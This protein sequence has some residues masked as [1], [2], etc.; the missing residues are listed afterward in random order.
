MKKIIL[1]VS[2]LLCFSQLVCSD[3]NWSFPAD[4]ISSASV[5]VND[6]QIAMD[7]NGN[8]TAVW[9]ENGSVKSK[10][11]AIGMGWSGIAILSNANSSWPRVVAHSNGDAT[12]IWLENGIV[13]ASTKP[14]NGNWSAAVNISGSGASTP[15]LAIGSSGAL[16]AVWVRNKRVE[17]STKLA[18]QSWNS[19]L[20]VSSANAF[21]PKVAIGGTGEN[22]KAVAV[23]HTASNGNKIV[24]ASIKPITKA[25][26]SQAA[27][28]D[29]NY[30]AEYANVA[31]DGNGNATAVW[32]KYEPLGSTLFNVYVQSADSLPNKTWSLPVDL[33][34]PGICDP[35]NLTA[36]IAY[37][38]AGNAIAL[39]TM[40]FD[41][42]TFSIQSAYK[43][44]F[45]VWNRAES[46]VQKNLYARS[47]DVSVSA[48]GDALALYMFYN[49]SDLIIQSSSSD[50]TGYINNVWS[51]PLNISE[52]SYNGNPRV[53]SAT[54][55]DVINAAALWITYNGMNTALAASTGP[56]AI[57]APP[58]NLAVMQSS[59][60]FGVFTE[61]ANT[62]SWDAS[63]DP[64]V[65][66][67]LI[68]RD[69]IFLA[70]VGANVLEYIDNNQTSNGSVTYGVA[71]VDDQQTH[72]RVISVSFP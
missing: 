34:S 53:A 48:F 24:Y 7:P 13:K 56:K 45:S 18:G 5:N 27:L 4:I 16:V 63:A 68:Y 32:F 72:G 1:M 39:W 60:N 42:E 31:V 54:S 12:A 61:Y 62:V 67:Y 57:P 26:G 43:P 17:A 8:S 38:G 70:K 55:G 25:W 51:V 28:S 20:T 36:R 49:G 11:K 71:S 69:G 23:W 52:G 33:S 29:P 6:P 44:A 40:S 30:C 19:S 15:D 41:D 50:I 47:A 22:E 14:F 65:T 59:N 9:L 3:Y 64:N 46:L 10:S 2:S 66:G 21:S 37:D 35:E 58:S